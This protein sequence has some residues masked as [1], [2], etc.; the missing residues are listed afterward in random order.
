MPFR[1]EAQRRFFYAKASEPGAEGKQ[2][3]KML[4]KMRRETPKG[5]KLPERVKTAAQ[6]AMEE[7]FF[8]EIQSILSKK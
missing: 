1:S 8:S 4:R 6:L 2:F 3:K 7:G 5:T